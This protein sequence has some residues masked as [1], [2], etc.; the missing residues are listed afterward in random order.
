MSMR[1]SPPGTDH[2]L[3]DVQVMGIWNFTLQ[4]DTPLYWIKSGVLE[5]YLM[6]FRVT[7]R[8]PSTAGLVLHAEADGSG[9]DG[10]SFWIERRMGKKEQDKPTRRYMVAGDGLE[11][12]PIVTRAFSDDGSEFSEDVEVLVEG[13]A[14]VIFLQERK[15]KLGIRMHS[16][17]GCI[18]FFNSTQAEFD[19]VH[20]SGV[21]ITAMRKGPME[22]SGALGKREQR[23]MGTDDD[24][25]DEADAMAASTGRITWSPQ[26]R[27]DSLTA[28]S[29]QLL[30]ASQVKGTRSGQWTASTF[31]P[32]STVVGSGSHRT[33]GSFGSRTGR[34]GHRG[35]SGGA[36]MNKTA[37]VSPGMM[38]GTSESALK[39]NGGV[40]SGLSPASTGRSGMRFGRSD[41]W[42]SSAINAPATEAE[43]IKKAVAGRGGRSVVSTSRACHDFIP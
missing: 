39:R 7:T 13:Y 36:S 9:A 22:I 21:R 43:F 33:S 38:R 25:D 24:Q 30:S 17:R 8:C 18:A 6:T 15:V 19:D 20:F 1:R 37:P 29:T 41:G 27:N 42:V 31:L 40:I 11:S 14:A 12:K 2:S 26:V 16:G 34:S 23:I 3:D 28:T 4:G 32:D 35:Q 10:T 5:R